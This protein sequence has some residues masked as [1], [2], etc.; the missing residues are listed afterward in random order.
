[1]GISELEIGLLL[2]IQVVLLEQTNCE[3]GAT[4]RPLCFSSFSLPLLGLI[5][6][7][8][9]LPAV[10]QCSNFLLFPSSLPLLTPPVFILPSPNQPSDVKAAITPLI[11][12]QS[13]R[14]VVG[15]LGWKCRYIF[16]IRKV[17]KID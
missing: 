11:Q 6:M 8:G 15:I 10:T 3:R 7:L 12:A 4:K 16:V 13:S 2:Q 14:L 17:L 5:K 1:M 9:G